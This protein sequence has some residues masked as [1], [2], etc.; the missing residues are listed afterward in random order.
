MANKKYA[1]SNGPSFLDGIILDHWRSGKK[2]LPTFTLEGTN[3]TFSAKII[4]IWCPDKLRGNDEKTILLGEFVGQTLDGCSYFIMFYGYRGRRGGIL[5][6][7]ASLETDNPMLLEFFP[8]LFKKP[9]PAMENPVLT[10]LRAMPWEKKL[11]LAKNYFFKTLNR[12]DSAVAVAHI[13]HLFIKAKQNATVGIEITDHPLN[14][15]FF[16]VFNEICPPL[17]S[18]FRELGM[19]YFLVCGADI[20]CEQ[21]KLALGP[22]EKIEVE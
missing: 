12:G 22:N 18:F 14:K 8:A 3:R 9:T 6:A 19:E 7:L 16:R 2:D 10:H 11:E 1:V 21:V 5:E 15:T 4:A 13:L 20:D 17:N